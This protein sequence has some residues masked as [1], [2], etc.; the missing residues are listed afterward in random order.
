MGILRSTLVSLTVYIRL[1][2]IALPAPLWNV[3]HKACGLSPLT[4]AEAQALA[5]LAVV[6]HAYSSRLTGSLFTE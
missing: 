3:P 4:N 5:E 6:R 2:T 1:G